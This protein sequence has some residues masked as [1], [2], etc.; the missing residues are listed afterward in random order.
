MEVPPWTATK[1]IACR[2]N[3]DGSIPL[4]QAVSIYIGYGTSEEKD[5][6]ENLYDNDRLAIERLWQLAHKYPGFHLKRPGNAHA[7]VLLRRIQSL[8]L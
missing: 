5:K 6:T 7:K 8:S 4:G 3:W 1:L 2:K